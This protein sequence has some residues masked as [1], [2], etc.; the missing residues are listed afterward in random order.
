[1]LKAEVSFVVKVVARF[2]LPYKND[3]LY[4]NAISAILI[5]TRLVGDRHPCFERS[6]IVG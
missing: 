6:L 5:V 4:P 1:M 3:V 2:S